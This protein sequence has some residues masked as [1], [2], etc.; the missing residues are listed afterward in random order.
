MAARLQAT[1]NVM[2][3][4]CG[5]CGHRGMKAGKTTIALERGDFLLVM[6]NVPAQVCENCGEA[7]VVEQT[8]ARLLA[9]AEELARS[10]VQ[11][12]V[13]SFAA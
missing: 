10:G 13:R 2:M 12:E 9:E 4:R 6:R 11:L 7:F 8:T 3:R 1:E 5:I